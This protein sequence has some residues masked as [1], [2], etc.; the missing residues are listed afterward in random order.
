MEI[1]AL[2][3]GGS[4]DSFIQL[5]IAKFLNLTVVPTPGFKVMVGN[6]KIMTVEG[7]IP[8]LEVLPQGYKLQIPEVYVLLVAGGDLR[9]PLDSSNTKHT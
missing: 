4:S 2:I 5:W 8:S 6:F 1:Q 9:A 3:D 7:Y